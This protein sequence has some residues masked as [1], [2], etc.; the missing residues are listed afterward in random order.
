MAEQRLIDT[1]FLDALAS[2]EPTPGGGSAAAL[3]GAIAAGLVS[4]VCQLT[5]GQAR[6]AAVEEE[7]RQVL[8]R[9]EELRMRLTMLAEED[10]AVYGA[11]AQAQRMPR[12]TEEE[13]KQRAERM[14][15][16]LVECTLVPMRVAEACREL[17]SLCPLVVEKGNPAAVTDVGV[18]ALLAEAALRG[19][20]LQVLVN[21]KWLKDPAFVAEQMGRLQSIQEG[22]AQLK[23]D[24]VAAV[25]GVLQ[26]Q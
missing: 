22:T 9:S 2:S 3:A 5:L 10:M 6:F 17:L 23:E 19:A 24:V 16:A 15:A 7:I 26:G 21:L 11:F 1:R 14:R 13:R 12:R 18:A 8:S 20:G 25:E 4:M